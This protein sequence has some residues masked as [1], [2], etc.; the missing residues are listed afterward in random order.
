LIDVPVPGCVLCGVWVV[1]AKVGA[2]EDAIQ[3]KSLQAFFD[4][5][6]LVFNPANCATYSLAH[7]AMTNF[8][9]IVAAML[10]VLQA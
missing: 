8:K 2:S 9:V 5:V 3:Y 10:P 6:Y 1:Q 4:D 7:P